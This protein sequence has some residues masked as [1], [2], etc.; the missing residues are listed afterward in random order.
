MPLVSRLLDELIATP[1]GIFF[2]TAGIAIDMSLEMKDRE[3]VAVS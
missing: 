3:I 1:A 2:P